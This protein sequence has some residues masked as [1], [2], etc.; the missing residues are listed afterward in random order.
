V[1]WADPVELFV[2][3]LTTLLAPSQSGLVRDLEGAVTST[4]TNSDLEFHA[5][6]PYEPGDDRRYV[7]WRTSART[8]QLMVR[9]FEETRRSQVVVVFATQRDHFASDAEFELAVSVMASLSAQILRD[10]THAD[11]VTESGALR[12]TTVTSMLDDSCRLEP[13]P[14]RFANPREFVRTATMRLPPPSVVMV[15]CG[16]GMPDADLRAIERLFGLDCQTVA[17]RARLGADPSLAILSRLRLAT[18]GQL[19]DLQRLVGRMS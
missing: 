15:V 13:T 7:H 6:R 19:G 4:L 2:H 5:L 16:S 12:T 3:P 10:D 9:Q 17:F 1:R 18:V 14:R 8:G 11:V